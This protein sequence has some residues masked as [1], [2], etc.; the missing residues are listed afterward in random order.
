MTTSNTAPVSPFPLP[1]SQQDS[2][3]EKY[4]TKNRITQYIVVAL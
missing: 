3:T 4:L 2:H 1:S